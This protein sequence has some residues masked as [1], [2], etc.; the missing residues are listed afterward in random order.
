MDFGKVH[1]Y[2]VDDCGQPSGLI[3]AQ[4]LESFKLHVSSL[5]LPLVILLEQERTDE[6]CDGGRVR[7]DSDDIG[8]AFD[9]GV[10]PLQRIG[11]ADLRA[12]RGQLRSE[13]VP[14]CLSSIP[15]AAGAP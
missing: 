15:S 5:E 4:G 1:S 7:E 6:A 10:E 12:P 3:V 11:G 2:S 13:L 9:L 14:I 8:A